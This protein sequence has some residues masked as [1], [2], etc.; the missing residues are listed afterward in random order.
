MST[1]TGDVA[2]LSMLAEQSVAVTSLIVGGVLS[3]LLAIYGRR[4]DSYWDEI[5]TFFAFVIGIAMLAIAVAAIS[6]ETLGWFSVVLMILLASG[7]FLKPLKDIP[8]AAIAGVICASAAAIAGWLFLPETILGYEKW[9]VVAVLFFVVGAFV[10]IT[11]HLAGSALLMSAKVVS[12]KPV[13]IIVALLSI[14]EGAT[15][16]LLDQSLFSLL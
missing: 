10:H 12:W 9:V 2:D 11:L 4:D 7:L 14:A 6:Q 1:L 8:M 5:G 15:I 13:M 3:I 16:A